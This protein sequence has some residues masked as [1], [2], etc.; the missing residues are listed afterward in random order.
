MINVYD[1]FFPKEIQNKIWNILVPGKW[2][3]C[4]GRGFWH[5]NGLEKDDFFSEYLVNT[6]CKKID[7][8][9]TCKRIYANGQTAGQSGYPHE[10][11][12]NFTFLYF[13][14][15][16]WQPSWS[17]HLIFLNRKGPEGYPN[18]TKEEW[19]WEYEYNKND[20]I[21]KIITYKPNRA[22]LFPANIVHYAEAPHSHYNG[23]R[24]SLAFK[25]LNNK[26]DL[27]LALSDSRFPVNPE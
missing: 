5:T 25:F 19:D 24:V 18:F 22:V 6:I 26:E 20:E 27:P 16:E 9:F 1:D 10:D 13:P 12:S 11:D 14:N 23:L 2:G 4:P 21:D 8:P 7:R 17:G 3:I 15:P